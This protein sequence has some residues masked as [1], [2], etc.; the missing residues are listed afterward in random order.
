MSLQVN[1]LMIVVGTVVVVELPILL[2][3]HTGHLAAAF[4]LLPVMMALTGMMGGFNCAI[5]PLLYPAGVRSV[6]PLTVTDQHVMT[7]C[8]D[9]H[10]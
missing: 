4:L 1:G 9:L 5:S 3:L 2:A 10:I 8:T 7:C 6:A